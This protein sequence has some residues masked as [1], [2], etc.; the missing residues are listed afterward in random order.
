M[1]TITF[2]TEFSPVLVKKFADGCLR[3]E[4]HVNHILTLR[5]PWNSFNSMP[6]HNESHISQI[7]FFLPQ[8]K[9]GS[10]DT[11]SS[12]MVDAHFK[13]S[14]LNDLHSLVSTQAALDLRQIMTAS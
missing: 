10:N 2:V 7:Y 4:V 12:Y 14:T 9:V 13:T 8:N 3:F 1:H 6:K 5:I 11:Y